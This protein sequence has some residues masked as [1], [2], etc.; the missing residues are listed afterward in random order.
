M[1]IPRSRQLSAS[2]PT[3][4]HGGNWAPI[5]P[6]IEG[7]CW[8]L[9]LGPSS[10]FTASPNLPGLFQV[11]L[12]LSLTSMD[13]LPATPSYGRPRTDCYAEISFPNTNTRAKG[14]I[15]SDLHYFPGTPRKTRQTLSALESPIPINPEKAQHQ[16]APWRYTALFPL[17]SLIPS[18]WGLYQQSKQ[19]KCLAQCRDRIGTKNINLWTYSNYFKLNLLMYKIDLKYINTSKILFCHA[20]WQ[21]EKSASNSLIIIRKNCIKN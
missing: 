3:G 7:Q 19:E 14:E 18:P 15:I 1:L 10:Q 2:L 21:P 4:I 17:F 12:Y 5:W 6:L 13:V 20:P 8:H 9:F 11:L 16:A